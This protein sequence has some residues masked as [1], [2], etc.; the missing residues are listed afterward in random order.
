MGNGKDISKEQ[1]EAN[2]RR[3]VEESWEMDGDQRQLGGRK[4]LGVSRELQEPEGEE[5]LEATTR[6]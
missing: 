1:Q 3:A 4:E 6:M 5:V 2:L